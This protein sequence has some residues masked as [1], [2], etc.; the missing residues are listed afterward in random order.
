MGIELFDAFYGCY[1]STIY[2]ILREA[3]KRELTDSEFH[4]LIKKTS[5]IYGF[6]VTT[7][8]YISEAIKLGEGEEL[9]ENKDAWPF[10]DKKSKT[11]DQGGHVLK[12]LNVHENR[13]KNI[14]GF[15][16]STIEKMWL[17]SI[18][19]DPRMKLFLKNEADFPD[20]G[21]IEPLFNWN[22]FVQ[23]D[24]YLDGDPFEDEH[25]IKMFRTVLEG[26]HNH[27]RLEIKY[28]KTNAHICFHEDGSYE[29]GP[30][31]GMGILYIDPECMEY[32]ERDNKFRL[33]GNNPRFGRSMVNI[34]CIDSCK[35]VERTDDSNNAEQKVDHS[36]DAFM[37]KAVFELVD[38]KNALERFLLNFS[39][40]EKIAERMEEEDKYRITLT[41]DE[42]D[43]TDLVIKILSFGPYV[44]V[45][46]PDYFADLIYDRLQQQMQLL[47]DN[48]FK[49]D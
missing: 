17:K 36:K 37:R 1:F 14:M 9:E 23:F 28:R 29:T 32:S 25:Y 31:R 21:D 6:Q 40:N 15:P 33:I 19:C 39:Y 42:T 43:E 48:G 44:K 5:D 10:F 38:K 4:D 12:N 49:C 45:V 24:Q 47:R 41:Y 30:D 26:I 3:G 18:Y 46:S 34:A 27:S 8:N 13:F 7:N 16:L 22:D 2:H 35:A 11:E 20:L